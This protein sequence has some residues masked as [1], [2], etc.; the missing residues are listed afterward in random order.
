MSEQW[1][2]IVGFPTY[3]VSDLGNVRN[4]STGTV[5]TP[6]P[7]GFK[8]EYLGVDLH[9]GGRRF[10]RLVHRLVAAAF[11]PP[12]PDP[13]RTEVNH[14]DVNPHNNRAENLEWVTREENEAHK[15]F[16]EASYA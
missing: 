4:D 12:D 11:L 2:K 7:R 5:L 9:Q 8:N 10:P 13:R 3:S 14:F 15:K 16:M 6:F 1:R